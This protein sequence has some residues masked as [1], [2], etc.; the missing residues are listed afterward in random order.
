MYGISTA[1]LLALVA[2]KT[3]HQHHEHI[4]KQRSRSLTLAE[5]GGFMDADVVDTAEGAI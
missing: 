2:K 3:D 5:L 4:E 1:N